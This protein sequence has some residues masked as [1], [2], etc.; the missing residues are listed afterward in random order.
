MN[1]FRK[2]LSRVSLADYLLELFPGDHM[3][4]VRDAI[5]RADL[6]DLARVA[7]ICN[8]VQGEIMREI[9]ERRRAAHEGKRKFDARIAHALKD[10]TALEGPTAK[11]HGEA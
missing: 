9:A 5:T 2:A 7:P 6:V 8:E 3:G 11:W 1:P 10:K 4:P